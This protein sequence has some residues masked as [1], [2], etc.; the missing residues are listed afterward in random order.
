MLDE[1]LEDIFEQEIASVAGSQKLSRANAEMVVTDT[2]MRPCVAQGNEMWEI[3]PEHAERIGRL[4]I[5]AGSHSPQWL[6]GGSRG[7][8]EMGVKG[9]SETVGYGMRLMAKHHMDR[10]CAEGKSPQDACDIVSATIVRL[11]RAVHQTMR[12]KVNIAHV[13]ELIETLGTVERG[14]YYN[15]VVRD[16]AIEAIDDQF[17]PSNKVSARSV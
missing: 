16:P 9:N 11:A 10:L 17:R 4:P 5:L 2:I 12:W 14:P 6:S 1:L 8:R 3:N 15:A 13:P 7:L